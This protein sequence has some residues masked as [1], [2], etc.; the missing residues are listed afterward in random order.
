MNRHVKPERRLDRIANR[1]RQESQARAKAMRPS[2]EPPLPLAALAQAFTG[3]QRRAP[4]RRGAGG[5]G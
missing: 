4:G 3:V 5:L 1:L 2:F